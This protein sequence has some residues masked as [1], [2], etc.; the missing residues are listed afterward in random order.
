[1]RVSFCSRGVVVAT[2]PD[3]NT[4][5]ISL[6]D[7][8]AAPP[9]LDWDAWHSYLKLQFFDFDLTL[10][11]DPEDLRYV[12][13]RYRPLMNPNIARTIVSFVHRAMK[14][15]V[16][17]LVHCE[18]GVS[19]SAAVAKWITDQYNLPRFNAVAL[20]QHNRYVYQLLVDAH[21]DNHDRS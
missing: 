21:K 2:T 13:E 6:T 7:P 5:L 4:A 8:T 3:P 15:K 14:A 20:M 19:R 16:N 11:T 18:A 12:R 1:M 10:I 9:Q 17:I